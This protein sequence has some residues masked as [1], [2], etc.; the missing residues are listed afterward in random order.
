MLKKVL[1]L[2]IAAGLTIIATFIQQIFS[3]DSPDKH[4]VTIHSAE[5][6]FKLPVVNEGD[7]LCQIELN[8]PDSSVTGT[9]HYKLLKGS[10]EWKTTRFI[11][12]HEDMLIG[13]LPHQK[14]NIKLE[15]YITLNSEKAE[16]PVAKSSPV[17]VR[18][19]STVP[20]FVLFPQVIIMFIALILCCFTG[21][22]SVFKI[23]SYKKYANITFYLFVL[24]AFIL[25]FVIHIISFRHILV[26]IS[27]HN[28]LSFYKNII[29]TLLWLGLF[30]INKRTSIQYFT[31]IISVVTLILF[32]MPTHILFG[33]IHY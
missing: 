10:D 18:F 1:F 8:I 21:I 19:Q 26:Q 24:G 3:S 13:I 17:V 29:I 23:E 27:P 32:C 16:F 6:Q 12:M 9:L 31:I 11:R 30:Y 28:D 14:P 33:W 20:K 15:Y 5:Y 22:L 4:Y 7:E 25:G 2:V